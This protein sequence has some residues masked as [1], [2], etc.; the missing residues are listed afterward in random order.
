MSNGSKKAAR[1]NVHKA[2]IF[3]GERA[4]GAAARR[5]RD[6]RAVGS[7]ALDSVFNVLAGAVFLDEA[8]LTIVFTAMPQAEFLNRQ[9]AQA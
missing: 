3:Q 9:G 7:G 8:V 4:D 6:S 5:S 1:S 2:E